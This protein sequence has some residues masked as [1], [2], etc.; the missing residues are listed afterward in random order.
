MLRRVVAGFD[1]PP[2]VFFADASMRSQ[3]RLSMHILNRGCVRASLENWRRGKL[4]S[5]GAT[6]GES[7]EGMV[8]SYLR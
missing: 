5:G 4:E 7:I 2:H 6:G 1:L 3:L 8:S